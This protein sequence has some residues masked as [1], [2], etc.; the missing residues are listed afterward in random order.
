MPPEKSD[1]IC[2]G[3]GRRDMNV[4]RDNVRNA[5]T[6]TEHRVCREGASA[7]DRA[8]GCGVARDI[9]FNNKPNGIPTA[10]VFY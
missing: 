7:E 2:C 3:T 5:E 1:T 10:A 4:F 6:S 8:W 9:C